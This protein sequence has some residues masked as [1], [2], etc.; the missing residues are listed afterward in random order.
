MEDSKIMP[1]MTSPRSMYKLY[2]ISLAEERTSV[3]INSRSAASYV[4]KSYYFVIL[5]I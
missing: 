4:A 1:I 2:L 3:F 5:L